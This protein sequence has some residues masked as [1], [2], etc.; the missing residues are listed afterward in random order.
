[1]TSHVVDILTFPLQIRRSVAD[2][3]TIQRQHLPTNYTARPFIRR[4]TSR[5]PL[6]HF[7][8][9]GTVVVKPD[10]PVAR[11]VYLYAENDRMLAGKTMSDPIT[12]AFE[13]SMVWGFLTY[14]AMAVDHTGQ[15]RAEAHD[16]LVPEPMA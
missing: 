7:R 12:G 8:V 4:A 3:R 15:Y 9:R 11:V 6:R 1:M 16:G 13:F 5:D 10:T 14:T 2:V